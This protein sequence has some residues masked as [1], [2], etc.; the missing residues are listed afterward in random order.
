MTIY[1]V[2][3]EADFVVR[4]TGMIG[5]DTVFCRIHLVVT[6]KYRKEEGRAA[7]YVR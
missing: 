4:F 6:Q 1:S 5:S 2:E 7:N 3:G